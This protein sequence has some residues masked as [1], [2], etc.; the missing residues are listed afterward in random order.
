M[1]RRSR[2]VKAV[3]Y[4]SETSAGYAINATINSQATAV[5]DCVAA[6]AAQGTRKVKNFTLRLSS[7]LPGSSGLLVA[8]IY[9][10]QGF[11]DSAIVLKASDMAHTSPPVSMFEPNQNVILTGY[12]PTINEGQVTYRSR[13]ARNLDSGDRIVF[14]LYNPLATAVTQISLSF[15]VNYAIAY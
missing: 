13:L 12:M 1:S 2:P 10:P 5:Y 3:K 11:P 8:L 7:S 4:S 14:C 9:V 15:V 6:I